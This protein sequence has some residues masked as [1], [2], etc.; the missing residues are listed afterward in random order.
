MEVV[1]YNGS[2]VSS[3]DISI[4]FNSR[5]FNYGDG[6]FETIKI[7]NAKPFNFMSHLNR[8]SR[9]LNILKLRNFELSNFEKKII[10]LISLNNIING[11]VKIH[12]SRAG[13]GKYLPNSEDLDIL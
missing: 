11:I 5:A 12:I 8:I 7:I 3:R 4:S 13:F 6:F 10:H 9:A 1:F 2:F